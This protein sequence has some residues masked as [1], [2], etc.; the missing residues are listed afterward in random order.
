MRKVFFLRVG[1]PLVGL[2]CGV[3]E[4]DEKVSHMGLCWWRYGGVN[5]RRGSALLIFLYN[6]VVREGGFILY[7][8]T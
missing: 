8:K 4:V 7:G 1:A 6:L 2:M 5:A 3:D